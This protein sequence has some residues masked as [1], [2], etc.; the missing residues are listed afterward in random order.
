MDSFL[1]NCGTREKW[2]G[3]DALHFELD[4]R[5]S[6]AVMADSPLKGNPWVWRAR[7]FNADHSLDLAM[8]RRGFHLAHTDISELCGG[9]EAIR[10][11]NAFYRRLTEDL[12]FSGLPVLEAYSRG[13]LPA[14]NWGIR[15]PLRTAAILADNPICNPVSWPGTSAEKELCRKA[16][17]LTPGNEIIPEW[18]PMENLAPL[19]ENKIPVIVVCDENDPGALSEDNAD[20]LYRKLSEDGGRGMRIVRKDDFSPDLSEKLADLAVGIWKERTEK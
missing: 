13:T 15:N 5:A 19:I 12:K 14:L 11:M 4:G 16:G 20:L 7:F 17:I 8:L 18:N 3:Y 2:K 1:K 6:I 9:P 10:R